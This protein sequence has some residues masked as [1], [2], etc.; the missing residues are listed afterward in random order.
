MVEISVFW[1]AA[2]LKFCSHLPENILHL[3]SKDHVLMLHR[4]V[5]AV[6]RM[7]SSWIGWIR[8]A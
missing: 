2:P 1:D 4:E 5:I 3:C 8:C 6:G 7:W